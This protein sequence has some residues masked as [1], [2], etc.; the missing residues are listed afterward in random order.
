MQGFH[1]RVQQRRRALGLTQQD[2]A[3]HLGVSKVAVS[4]WESGL[5]V[6]NGRNLQHLAAL[7]K[8]SPDWLLGDANLQAPAAATTKPNTDN[9]ISITLATELAVLAYRLA[10]HHGHGYNDAQ[11]RQ[12]YRL[13][14]KI[15]N[16][17]KLDPVRDEA[18]IINF[19]K[20][21]MP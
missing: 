19:T 6:A 5:N 11:I 20:Y 21:A 13:L 7:L 10:A 9:P 12:L 8:C 4:K 3:Q 15:I 2:I 18:K 14:V 16:E 17:E 1:H